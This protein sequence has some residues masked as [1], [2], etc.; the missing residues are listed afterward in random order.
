VLDWGTVSSYACNL[1]AFNILWP[2][3]VIASVWLYQ[4]VWCKL[5]GRAPRHQEIVEA[6][7]FLDPAQAR[8]LLYGLGAFECVLAAW[9]LSGI[10]LREA[11]AAQTL[12]L[13]SM[14]ITAMFRARDLISDPI[15]MLLQNTAFLT[16]VWVASGDL[17][18]YA[19]TR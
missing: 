10:A 17:H 14:N 8:L 13:V 19:T 3:V 7:A 18:C 1:N 12:V 16:L 6:A 2:R 5:L 11:A 15:G 4:G 9:M